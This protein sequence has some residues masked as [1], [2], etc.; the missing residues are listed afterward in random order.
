MR[1]ASVFEHL[2]SIVVLVPAGATGWYAVR[3]RSCFEASLSS[4]SNHLMRIRNTYALT[5][6]LSNSARS[7]MVAVCSRE[8][9]MIRAVRSLIFFVYLMI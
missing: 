6:R 5:V 7:W 9:L 1:C 3:G 8:Q 2:I 4:R